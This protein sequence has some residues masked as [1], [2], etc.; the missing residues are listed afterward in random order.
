MS[1]KAAA[2]SSSIKEDAMKRGCEHSAP[3][4]GVLRILTEALGTEDVRLKRRSMACL[5]ELLFYIAAMPAGAAAASCWD[6]E[7]DT[8]SAIISL[9]G[10]SEDT[11]VQ[12]L[13][14]VCWPP[15]IACTPLSIK[16]KVVY[17]AAMPAKW[18]A[19][20]C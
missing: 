7:D 13:L 9:L 1:A 6:V 16:E 14:H 11:T 12:V 2:A 3:L 10:P 20:G 18:E 8:L 15:P 4:T 5:G 17:S 19:A